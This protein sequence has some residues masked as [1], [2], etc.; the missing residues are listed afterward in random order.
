MA[1]VLVKS[2][3]ASCDENPDEQMKWLLL[4]LE[5]GLP[6][7]RKLGSSTHWNMPLVTRSAP[8]CHGFEDLPSSVPKAY[9]SNSGATPRDVRTTMQGAPRAGRALKRTACGIALDVPKLILHEPPHLRV[10]QNASIAGFCH[11]SCSQCF[12]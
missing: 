9:R 5:I 3:N 4:G 6:S 11:M 7:G 1:I 10:S 8:P 2:I 12:W